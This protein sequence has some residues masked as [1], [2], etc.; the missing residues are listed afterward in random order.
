MKRNQRP[1]QKLQMLLLQ[2]NRKPVNNTPEDLQQL[3]DSVVALGFVDEA[4]EDVGDGCDG[5]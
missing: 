1:N 2:R 5:R 4:V 3:S